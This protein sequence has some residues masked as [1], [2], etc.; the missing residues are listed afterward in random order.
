MVVET[1]VVSTFSFSSSDPSCFGGEKFS[2][3]FFSTTDSLLSGI[4]L[5]AI[6]S[7]STIRSVYAPVDA[8]SCLHSSPMQTISWGDSLSYPGRQRSSQ[9]PPYKIKKAKNLKFYLQWWCP[10]FDSSRLCNRKTKLPPNLVLEKYSSSSGS[11]FPPDHHSN[12]R[13]GRLRR[14]YWLARTQ[15]SPYN[16]PCR[17]DCTSIPCKTSPSNS[18][19]RQG[20]LR[21]TGS[22]KFAR[23]QGMESSRNTRRGTKWCRPEQSH[24]VA[25]GLARLWRWLKPSL[26]TQGYF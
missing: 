26:L 18:R 1:F 13:T 23:N 2:I 4:F 25:S 6:S 10:Y 12:L 7:I 5:Q 21:E 14:N 16:L 11:L 17:W 8:F 20:C 19:S 9:L 15:E 3:L 24:P 22:L